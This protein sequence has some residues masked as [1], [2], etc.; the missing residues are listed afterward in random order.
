MTLLEEIH[1]LLNIFHGD[2]NN[3][4]DYWVT[5]HGKDF[6]NEGLEEIKLE[7]EEDILTWI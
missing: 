1:I 6:S 7:L 4:G 2:E 3:F 5:C